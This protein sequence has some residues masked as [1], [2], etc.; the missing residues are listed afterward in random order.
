M[1]IVAG[2]YGVFVEFIG[3]LALIFPITSV[4]ESDFSILKYEKD[5]YRVSMT[6]FT[7]QSILHCKQLATITAIPT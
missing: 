3:G 7:L 4:V 6:D 5:P 2:R 1:A